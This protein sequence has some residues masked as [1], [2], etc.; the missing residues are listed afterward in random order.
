MFMKCVIEIKKSAGYKCA[1][2]EG[3]RV[4]RNGSTSRTGRASECP[5]ALKFKKGWVFG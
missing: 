2:K 5:M 3:K 1:A 4:E